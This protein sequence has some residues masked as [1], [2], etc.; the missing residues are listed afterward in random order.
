MIGQNKY[1]K[2]FRD[3]NGEIPELGDA[4]IYPAWG[5]FRCGVI[6]GIVLKDVSRGE[7]RMHPEIKIKADLKERFGSDY[8]KVSFKHCIIIKKNKLPIVWQVNK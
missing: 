8:N 3:V 7:A 5:H 1:L 4:V 2:Q 6:D